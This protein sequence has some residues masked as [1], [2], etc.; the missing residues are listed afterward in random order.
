MRSEFLQQKQQACQMRRSRLPGLLLFVSLISV[1]C[2]TAAGK[3]DKGEKEKRAEQRR[4]K[5]I[6][7][8]ARGDAKGALEY[9]SSPGALSQIQRAQVLEAVGRKREAAE[10]FLAA[11]QHSPRGDKALVR[12]WARMRRTSGAGSARAWGNATEVW[13]AV[14]VLQA[15]LLEE[16]GSAGEEPGSLL[17]DARRVVSGGNDFF[18]THLMLS[19]CEDARGRVDE[20]PL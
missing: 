1:A 11:L 17:C 15:A 16:A 8:I 4:R 18:W 2:C 5:G 3:A 6:A 10:Q 19:R 14:N 20:V 13:G 7:H 12:A 9:L